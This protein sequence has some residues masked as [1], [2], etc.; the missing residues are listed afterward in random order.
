MARILIVDDEAEIRVML[1]NI[2]ND[3]YE[4]VE[5]TNGVEAKKICD[6]TDVD[7]MITDI[8]MPEMHGVD[9]VLEIRRDHP[10]MPIIAMSGGGGVTGRFDYL[11]IVSLLGVE[12]VMQK[13]FEMSSLRKKVKELL[14][15]KKEK[16]SC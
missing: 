14:E 2:F 7:L 6:S 8:V 16:S 11:K 10:D 13:P 5:A 12:E 3:N 4:I 15:N 1:N 9:L